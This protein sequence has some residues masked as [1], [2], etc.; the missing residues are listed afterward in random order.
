MAAPVAATVRQSPTGIKLEKGY[1]ILHVFAAGPTKLVNIWEMS[2]KPLGYD[3]GDPIDTST[4]ENTQ[5]KTKAAQQLIDT[6]EATFKFAYDPECYND[7]LA[8]VNDPTTITDF[9]P[10]GSTLAYFGYLQKVEFDELVA[11]AMPTGTATIASTNY[12]PVGRV[13]AKPVMTSVAG[14]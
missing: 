9:F 5:F 1:R 10:D 13:E 2:G 3:G 11:D 12:D 14:T 4:F 7:L 6:T 8:L